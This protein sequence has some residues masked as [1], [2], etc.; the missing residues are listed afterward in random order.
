MKTL[1]QILDNHLSYPKMIYKK[2]G[3]IALITSK[4]MIEKGH[5]RVNGITECSP[6]APVSAGSHIQYGMYR[7]HRNTLR[8]V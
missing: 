6:D 3:K 1:Q 5:V 4:S 2:N 8:I 7:Y